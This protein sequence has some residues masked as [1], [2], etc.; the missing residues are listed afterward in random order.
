MPVD[1]DNNYFQRINK[2]LQE[3][4]RAIPFLLIDLDRLDQN[5]ELL[6]KSIVNKMDYRIVVKSLPSLPLI[7]Y[8]IKKTGT[9]KL[10]VFHQPFLSA[11]AQHYGEE[12]DVLLGKP[13]P[14]KTAKYFY[15]NI[16][17]YSKGFDPYCQVQW[18]VDTT[19]RID[20]YV[21]MAKLLGKKIRLNLEIDVGLHRG[22]FQSIQDL[23]KALHLL[24]ANSDRVLLSGFM[25]YDPHVVK[26]PTMVRSQSKASQMANDFYDQCKAILKDEFP[27]LWSEHLTFNGAGSPTINLHF[28]SETPLNDISAGSCLVKPSTF[29]IPSLE[30]YLPSAFIAT[31]VLKKFEG[32]LIPGI[33]RFKSILSLASVKNK[34]SY[35]IYGGFWKAEYCFPKGLSQNLIFSASTNQTMVN[36]GPDTDLD[37]DDFVFLRPHQSEFV[38]LQFGKIL[39]VKNFEIVEKW[40]ILSN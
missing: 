37:V 21:A 20:Q 28:E 34:R 29:D 7:D 3:H 39:A 12:I 40:D 16:A 4:D 15:E 6:Q 2:M 27:A 19:E 17:G 24:I 38:F 9:H 22:G 1:L 31:P 10:M 25:G 26:L 30:G 32:T 35:F 23:R 8:I 13:M 36:V 33:E 11:I 5:I 18:L 14:I